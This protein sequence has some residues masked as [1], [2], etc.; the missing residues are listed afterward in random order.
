MSLALL[1]VAAI[2]I[3]CIIINIIIIITSFHSHG[4]L[5]SQGRQISH[6]Q[7]T[8]CFTLIENI[9]STIVSRSVLLVVYGFAQSVHDKQFGG[10][11]L[12][13]QVVNAEMSQG[14][15]QGMARGL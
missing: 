13:L 3:K 8:I 2:K 7:G 5:V 4:T 10:S 1:S 11:G 15:R 6:I 12:L 14:W 9:L